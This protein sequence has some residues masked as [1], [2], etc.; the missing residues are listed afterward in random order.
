MPM[1]VSTL[2]AS[3]G[4]ATTTLPTA[5]AW[6]LMRYINMPVRASSWKASES[7]CAC[8]NR[9]LRKSR[10]MRWSTLVVRYSLTTVKPPP[11]SVMRSVDATAKRMSGP[12][13]SPTIEVTHEGAARLPSTV[14]MMNANGHGSAS[15]TTERAI[16]R[17]IDPAA[18]A[19]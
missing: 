14:S 17:R 9:S 12:L 15:A 5:P 16:V 1:S 3:S 13:S 2:W 7:R 4:R 18:S 8:W 10:T 11:A 19:L 6:L